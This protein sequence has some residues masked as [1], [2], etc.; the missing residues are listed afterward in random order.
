[1]RSDSMQSPTGGN[2]PV[3]RALPAYR[4]RKQAGM[5]SLGFI[6]L[7]VFIGIY[8]YAAIRLAPIYLNYVKIVGVRRRA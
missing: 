2:L 4:L 3:N 7:V 6:I 5:T 1:M 8:G